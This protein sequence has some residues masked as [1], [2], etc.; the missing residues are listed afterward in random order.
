[1]P[2]VTAWEEFAKEEG[3]QEGL[4]AGML[5][6][7]SSQLEQR[8]GTIEPELKQQLEQLDTQRL[9]ELGN[10]L[11]SLTSQAELKAWLQSQPVAASS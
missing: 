3:K 6:L 11:F 8:L 1:M 9:Q 5:I 10:R 7:L 2:Y 4:Q